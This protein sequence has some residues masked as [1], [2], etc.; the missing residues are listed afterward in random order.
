VPWFWE[1]L[2]SLESLVPLIVPGPRHGRVLVWCS[3]GHGDFA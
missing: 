2:V 1:A 3:C